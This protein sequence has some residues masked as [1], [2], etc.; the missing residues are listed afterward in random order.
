MTRTGARSP[1][2]PSSLGGTTSGCC[3]EDGWGTRYGR[4]HDTAVSTRPAVNTRTFAHRAVAKGPCHVVES[5][6]VGAY[7]T[8]TSVYAQ[9]RKFCF[10][11]GKTVQP[12]VGDTTER[13]EVNAGVLEGT[14]GPSTKISARLDHCIAAAYEVRLWRQ[15]GRLGSGVGQHGQHGICTGDGT[16]TRGRD[17]AVCANSGSACDA[18]DPGCAVEPSGREAGYTAP[19]ISSSTVGASDVLT[20]IHSVIVGSGGLGVAPNVAQHAPPLCAPTGGW[21][22]AANLRGGS[23]QGIVV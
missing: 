14:W 13:L 17:V 23:V 9:C 8:H 2:L 20:T 5:I 21:C 11:F 10:L 6:G 1:P 15:T 12:S 4:T 22:A 18:F 19:L 16:C 7:H 3:G